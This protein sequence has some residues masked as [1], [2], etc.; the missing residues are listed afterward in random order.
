[1][2]AHT[3]KWIL[4]AISLAVSLAVIVG[5]ISFAGGEKNQGRVFSW[6]QGKVLFDYK[7]MKEA[8]V[9]FDFIS[10][11]D[12]SWEKNYIAAY[13]EKSNPKYASREL[14]LGATGE[15]VAVLKAALEEIGYFNLV[16]KDAVGKEKNSLVREVFPSFVKLNKSFN[17]DQTVNDALTDLPKAFPGLYESYLEDK[18]LDQYE[19]VRLLVLASD[20]TYSPALTTG[21]DYKLKRVLKEGSALPPTAFGAGYQPI[22]VGKKG[23]NY[24][25][26]LTFVTNKTANQVSFS[27]LKKGE[28][29][30]SV[31][32]LKSLLGIAGSKNPEIKKLGIALT[33]GN[34]YDEKTF[35]LV[36][37][38]QK[39]YQ[40][41]ETGI[42]SED[43][44]YFL[45]KEI[46]WGGYSYE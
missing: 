25:H 28:E 14:A 19:L 31:A 6:K 9:G 27:S 30:D 17:Y 20:P 21:F 40:L 1:M 11:Q 2:K 24:S 3:S 38:Y 41:E 12:P 7:V 36:K 44:V 5:I 8:P 29:S 16:S 10:Y 37:E 22:T 13:T 32:V 15:D 4:L 46:A 35:L 39:V 18:S 23:N 45:I 34:D 26:K 33:N 43:L 42:A